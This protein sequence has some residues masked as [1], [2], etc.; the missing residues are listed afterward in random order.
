MAKRVIHHTDGEAFDGLT[1]DGLYVFRVGNHHAA[2]RHDHLFHEL[3]YVERGEATQVAVDHD[4]RLQHG[5]VIV[6]RPGIWHAYEDTKNFSIINCLM[7]PQTIYRLSALLDGLPGAFELLRQPATA[8]NGPTILHAAG[9]DEGNTIAQMLNGIIDEQHA[10]RDGHA[11]ANLAR[12]HQ[13]LVAT[14]R[15]FE[16]KRSH[17][18]TITVTRADEAVV[19]AVEYIQRHH[20]EQIA[21][22]ALAQR[23]HL[24]PAHLSRSFTKR[25]GMGV[26]D[27]MHR[28]RCEQ[29]CRLL[30]MSRL[31]IGEI[32]AKVGYD[33]LAY[34]S[35][36]FRRHM[37]M[38]PRVYRHAQ[39]NQSSDD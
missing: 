19:Q 3:V 32:A 15:L 24:S 16:R 36:R 10:G 8:D 11:A 6:L 21:L 22:E 5:D 29:A 26:I 34:F 38:S 28:L 27:F 37:G 1:R 14:V 31:Q 17:M 20:T 39:L 23:V 12:L 4:Q 18:R 33:E 2:R 13:V 9:S 30:C 25:V 35:R 7:Q